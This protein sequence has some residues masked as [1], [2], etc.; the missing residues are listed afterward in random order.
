MVRTLIILLIVVS[1]ANTV[2]ADSIWAKRD[3][4]AKDAFTDDVA[5]KIGDILTIKISEASKVDNKAKRDLQKK[6]SK[7]VSFNGKIGDYIDLGEFGTD[8]SADNTLNGKADFK[9]E[10]S[11]VDSISVVVIDIMPNG[12]LVVKGIRERNIGGDIQI[13]ETSGIVRVSDISYDNT[14]ESERVND[15]YIVSKSKG[16][17]DPYTRPGWLGRL[18]DIIWP[19]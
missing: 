10:R 16:V 12:N 1:G 17:A 9:D 11:F 13:I 3:T 6:V 2:C 7:S 8:A 5:R 19:F 4:N 18:L 15:F 14:V